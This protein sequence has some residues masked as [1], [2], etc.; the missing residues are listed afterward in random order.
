VLHTLKPRGFTA[1]CCAE[2]LAQARRCGYRVTEVPVSPRR[3]R[4]GVTLT[5]AA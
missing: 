3:P 4:I 2:L 1:G 5:Q